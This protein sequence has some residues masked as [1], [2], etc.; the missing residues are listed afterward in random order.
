MKKLLFIIST[1]GSVVAGAQE[2]SEHVIARAM[3]DEIARN[4]TELQLDGHEKP[5][6]IAYGISDVKHLEIGAM[7]GGLFESKL[8]STRG[9]WTTRVM[10]GNYAVNDE[11]YF[12]RS[13]QLGD[14]GTPR[15]GLPVDDHYE[16]IRRFLWL[17]TNDVYKSAAKLQKSKVEMIREFGLDSLPLRDFAE[18][19][20]LKKYEKVSLDF[21]D[22]QL[23]EKQI[24]ELSNLFNEGSIFLRP[25]ISFQYAK[26]QYF[27]INSEGTE[28]ILPVEMGLFSANVQLLDENQTLFAEQYSAMVKM[29]DGLADFETIKSDL[30]KFKEAVLAKAKMSVFDDLYFGP[31]LVQGKLTADFLASGLIPGYGSTGI[32]AG[33]ESLQKDNER[34][35]KT[36]IENQ[37]KEMN[38]EPRR[39]AQASL[40]VMDIPYL[41]SYNGVPLVGHYEIDGEGVVPPDTLVIIDKGRLVGQLNGRTPSNLARTSNGHRRLGFG[42]GMNTYQDTAPGVLFIEWAN[43]KPV[44]QL[45]AQLTTEA[46][47][48]QLDYALSIEP[49]TFKAGYSTLFSSYKI[50]TTNGEKTSVRLGNFNLSSS[51]ALMKILGMSSEKTVINDLMGAG[52]YGNAGTMVSIICP[53][54]VLIE[55]FEYNSSE[56]QNFDLSR[57]VPSLPSPLK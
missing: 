15:T 45:E 41:Q 17:S 42:Y 7:M 21:P 5:F 37:L 49:V 50:N 33:R 40:S 51:N 38:R 8:D 6:Y 24:I 31:V 20:V 4:M 2:L 36:F 55:G 27:F 13:L 54:A 16:G 39:I 19:P 23:V 29:N 3:R 32:V 46:D 48:M 43:G 22:K 26:G 25:T 52:G 56:A 35:V 1:V 34:M 12:D 53:T 10:V 30:I 44:K 14:G 11:N 9:G 47:K 18:A 28:I 57:F